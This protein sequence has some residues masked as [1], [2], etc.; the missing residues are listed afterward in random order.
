LEPTAPLGSG[1]HWARQEA[2][3]FPAKAEAQA[4][5]ALQARRGPRVNV[6]PLDP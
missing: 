1:G 5:L 4:L 2:L 3:G 6:A